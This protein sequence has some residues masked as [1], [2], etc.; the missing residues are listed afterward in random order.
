MFERSAYQTTGEISLSL[1]F[2]LGSR[3]N[4][5][6]S[7]QLHLTHYSKVKGKITKISLKKKTLNQ[8]YFRVF[9]SRSTEEHQ[10]RR[11]RTVN[12]SRSS[13][14]LTLRSRCKQPRTE[15]VRQGASQHV[16]VYSLPTKLQL[17]LKIIQMV[18]L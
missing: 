17:T 6:G 9:L 1:S 7:S 4:H 15:P 8:I 3:F 12:C 16:H 13:H 2:S 14:V 18:T 11:Q 5:S 10:L